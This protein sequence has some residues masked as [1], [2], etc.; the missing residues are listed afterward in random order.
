MPWDHI[1]GECQPPQAFRRFYLAALREAWNPTRIRRNSPVPTGYIGHLD[2]FNLSHEPVTIIAQ[3]LFAG[4]AATAVA[5]LAILVWIAIGSLFRGETTL[6]DPTALPEALIIGSGLTA[7]VFAVLA[8]VG[9]VWPA[10]IVVGGAGAAA[11]VVRRRHVTRLCA[12]ALEPYAWALPG[13]AAFY[14][15]GLPAG[16]LLWLNA[17]APPRDGD[18]MRY[19]LAH[20]R[21]IV[22]DGG[23]KPILDYH[24]ALPFGWTLNYLPFE[25]LHL[26][27]AAQ[28]VNT[29]LFVVMLGGVLAILRQRNVSAVWTAAGV[30]LVAHPFVIRTFTSANADGYAIFVVFTLCALLLRADDFRPRDALAFG[31]VSWIGPQSRYQLVAV[32]IAAL[33]AILIFR[34]ASLRERIKPYILGAIGGAL[35]ASPFYV[36]N[37]RTFGNPVWPLGI[38]HGATSRYADVIGAAYTRSLGGDLAIR[39]VWSGLARMFTTPELIPIPAAVILLLLASM[40]SGRASVNRLVMFGFAFL[41]LWVIAQ[42]RLYPRFIVLLLPVAALVGGLRF[43][44]MAAAEVSSTRWLGRYAA[45]LTL[46]VLTLAAAATSL[47]QLRYDVT[48]NLARYHRFTWYYPVYAWANRALPRDARVLVIVSSGHSYYLERQYRRADP[49]LSAEVDW[50]HTTTA[51]SL[52]SALAAGREDY[53]IYDDRDWSHFPAGASM[54]AAIKESIARGSLIP[55]HSFQVPLYSSRMRRRFQVARVYVLARAKPGPAGI[56]LR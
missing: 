53:V 1:H 23:W 11:L 35:L 17:I 41:T 54:S 51:S 6:P 43:G 3:V 20:V 25:L 46:A 9:I 47:D 12:Q 30:A 37:L 32:A 2:A 55:I 18:S 50:R 48:G 31:F 24:Y 21:Q 28:L 44:A 45:A 15:A 16:G 56:L 13:R 14:L 42:P 10:A 7:A 29:M 40:R 19:H 34:P 8:A 49:W 4:L 39:T 26:P 27:Q 52:D 22:Q 33:V 36:A 38:A 5:M